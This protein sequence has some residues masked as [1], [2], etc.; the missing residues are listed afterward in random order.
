[1]LLVIREMQMTTARYHCHPPTRVA[2][3]KAPSI[4]NV[5]EDVEQLER[6]HSHGGSAVMMQPLGKTIWQLLIKLKIHLVCDPT[7]PLLGISPRHKST[8]R[9]AHESSQQLPAGLLIIAKNGK[10]PK[11]PSVDEG[12]NRMCVSRQWKSGQQ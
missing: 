8:K 6:S 3:R 5:G 9:H 11:C 7:I 4:Q 12:M 10:Q 1:M 2:K